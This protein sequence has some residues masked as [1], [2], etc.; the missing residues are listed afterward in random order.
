ML[1]ANFG[2][3]PDTVRFEPP[4]KSPEFQKKLSFNPDTVRF[5]PIYVIRLLR[6]SIVSTPIRFDLNCYD[7]GIY[8][9]RNGFNPDTVR[10]ELDPEPEEGLDKVQFQPRYGSI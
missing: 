9:L 2:F 4:I 3:N 5:E 10:F 1:F 8:D 7:R 6:T